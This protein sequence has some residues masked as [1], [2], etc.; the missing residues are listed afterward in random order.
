MKAC[1]AA[2]LVGVMRL[3][4]CPFDGAWCL[5]VELCLLAV[6]CVDCMC[7][8][9][10]VFLGGAGCVELSP[11]NTRICQHACAQSWENTC[12]V[13]CAVVVPLFLSFLAMPGLFCFLHVTCMVMVTLTVFYAPTALYT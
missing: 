2:A 5:F 7:S 11:C 12:M 3:L 6:V 8:L 4:G 9:S 10:F 1:M 13:M